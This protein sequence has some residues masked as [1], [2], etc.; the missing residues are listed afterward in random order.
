MQLNLNSDLAIWLDGVRGRH[1]RQSYIITLIRQ[2]MTKNQQHDT[3]GHLD[4]EQKDN[5][6]DP[7]A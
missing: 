1:S 4:N 5:I 2:E 6:P 3:I 7:F